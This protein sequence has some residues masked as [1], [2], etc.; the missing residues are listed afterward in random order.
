MRIPASSHS[1]PHIRTKPHYRPYLHKIQSQCV[2]NCVL[3]QEDRCFNIRKPRRSPA[4]AAAHSADRGERKRRAAG[5]VS[6]AARKLDTGVPPASTVPPKSA[7]PAKSPTPPP[8]KSIAAKPAVPPTGK[9]PAS[10]KSTVACPHCSRRLVQATA[11]H[12][13]FSNGTCDGTGHAG[14]ARIAPGDQ[15][16]GNSFV[17]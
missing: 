17:G 10:P 8:A 7:A 6:A 11:A 5:R 9:S 12:T 14:M 3:H 1:R 16:W 13:P 4:T 15:G 2:P